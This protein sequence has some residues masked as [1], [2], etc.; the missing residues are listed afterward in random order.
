MK[1][2]NKIA[3]DF[4]QG[5]RDGIPI[6]LGYLSVSFTF[7]ITAAAKGLSAL[8]ATVI[9]MTNLTSAGQVAGLGIIAAGG[10]LIEMA[11]AQLIINMRYALMSI[12]LSQKL[13]GSF[14]LPHRFAAAFG[15]TDEIFAVASG[16]EGDIS[17]S[18]M[19]GL[20]LMPFI[21]WS[22]GTFLGAFAGEILPVRIKAALGIAIYG[23][24]IAIFIPPARKSAGVLTVVAVSA[25]LSCGFRYIPMLSGVSEGFVII[26]CALAASVAG[27]L[28]FPVKE[29]E[30][31]Q[32]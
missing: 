3:P 25:G 9:S 8:A 15:I 12:S 7:G 18:Y 19:Y 14:T 28:I 6:G 24:F 23:M 11:L 13:D 30:E 5:L 21:C 17:R 16:K 1:S 32:K 27:A 22:S 31:G 4:R 10:T 29:K 2:E 26:I 20:I